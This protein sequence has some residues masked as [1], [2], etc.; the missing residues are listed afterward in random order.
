MAISIRLDDDLEK[1]LE[2]LSRQ[3]GLSKDRIVRESLR[4]YLE[5]RSSSKTPYELGKV[6]TCLESTPAARMTWRPAVSTT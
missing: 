6:R 4:Q 2:L 1:E 5:T 3:T